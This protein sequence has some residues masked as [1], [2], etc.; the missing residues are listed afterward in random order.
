MYIYDKPYLWSWI[1]RWQ[2]LLAKYDIVYMKRKVVKGNAIVDLL[3]NNAVEDYELLDFDFP[4]EN[5]LLIEDEE[6]KT[7]WWTMYFDEA[8]NVYGNRAGA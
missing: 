4:N 5:V 7:D 1:V 8:V 2:V 3:A 6:K